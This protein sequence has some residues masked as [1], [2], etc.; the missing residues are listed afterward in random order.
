MGTRARKLALFLYAGAGASGRVL[1]PDVQA[2]GVPDSY[3]IKGAKYSLAKVME[4]KWI[5]P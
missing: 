2:L 5:F 3:L 4:V 1:A